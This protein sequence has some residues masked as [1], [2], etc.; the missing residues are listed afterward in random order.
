VTTAIDQGRGKAT[1]AT[2]P[3]DEGFVERDGVRVHWELFGSGDRTV[4]FLP[5][6]SIVH[7]RVWKGQVAHFARHARVLVFDPRGNGRSDRPADSA[8]YDLDEFVADA[9]AVMDATETARAA[10]VGLSLGA[11]RAL[12]L[13]ATAPERIDAVVCIGPTLPITE[14]SAARGAYAFDEA[15][16]TDEGWAK[17]N[18]HYWRRDFPGF[19]EFFFGQ[20]LPEPHSTKQFDDLLSWGL[21]TSAE[22]LI[23]TQGAAGPADRDAVL[24]L[25]SRVE[26]PVLVI[27]GDRDNITPHARGVA[28]AEATGGT[29]VTLEGSGHAL[30]GRDPVKVNL[31]ISEFLGL[32]PPARRLVRAQ[33]RTR[34]RVLY[35]SSPIGLG[36]AQRDLAIARELRALRPELEIVWLAQHPVTKVL[37]AAGE[38]IHPASRELAGESAHWEAWSDDHRLHAFHAWRAMDEVLLSNFMLFHDV[39]RDDHYDAWIGDEAWELDF[40][41]HENP[42]LKTAP[43][44]FLTDFVGWTPIDDSPGSRE[45]FLTS[46]YNAH[47]IELVERYPQVRDVAVFVGEPEDCVPRLFGPGL[48]AIPD[49]TAAHF[50]FSGYVLPF[51]P[52]SLTDTAA[53]RSELGLPAGPLVVGAVGGSGVGVHL[54]R[55]IAEA[56]RELRSDVPDARLLLVCGPRIDPASIDAVERMT[57]VGYVH[58]LFRTL[59]CCDLAVVQGGLTTTMELVATR[60]PFISIPLRD[61]FEQNHHV[62]YRL[63]RYGAPAP[64]PYEDATPE[65]LAQLMRERLGAPVDYRPVEPG[66]AVR[67]AKLLAA[68]LD[69]V[70]FPAPG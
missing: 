50:D 19:L 55:Q 24:E 14:T 29:I 54:L 1:W 18:A 63:Q 7:A 60:R 68:A 36:H 58:D 47:M 30:Q 23:A 15:L 25:C 37:E 39:V 34:P 66:G 61:H 53:I 56:F 28:L 48:P 69:L 52:A 21:E 8:A 45:S 4:L 9:L 40:F 26:C 2:P 17:Y 46:D 44:A 49:W 67:A 5:T 70:R 13:A 32:S 41:L 38:R 43:F 59:A 16:D 65:A 3:L 12:R 62:A 35:V 51:D 20:I 27:H 31:V 6:W 11:P 33:N 22:T 10:V 42:E 64:T 57:A